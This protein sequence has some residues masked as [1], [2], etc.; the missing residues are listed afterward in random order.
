MFDTL[1]S[2]SFF[3]GLEFL[4]NVRQSAF[5]SKGRFEMVAVG[6]SLLKKAIVAAKQKQYTQR[7]IECIVVYVD[8]LQYAQRL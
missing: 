7:A 6:K 3:K 8:V 1:A 2:I 4:F 5:L